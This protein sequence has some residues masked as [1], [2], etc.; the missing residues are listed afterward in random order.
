MN[1]RIVSAALV[2]ACLGCES[3]EVPPE[4]AARTFA[5]AL[6]IKIDGVSCAGVD[7]DSDGYVTCTVNRGDGQLWSLQCAALGA[8]D[9]GSKYATGCKQSIDKNPSPTNTNVTVVR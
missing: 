4:Q 9:F 1:Y 6:G 8:S 5:A 2:V 3:N 7:T